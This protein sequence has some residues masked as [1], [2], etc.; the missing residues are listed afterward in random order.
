MLV[1]LS[2][3]HLSDLQSDDE[4]VERLL[5]ET[6]TSLPAKAKSIGSKKIDILWLGDIIDLLVSPQWAQRSLRPWDSPSPELGSLIENIVVAT[7]ARYARFFSTM[8]LLSEK[9]ADEVP[10]FFHY[11]IGNHDWL[12]NSSVARSAR[13][14]V[15]KAFC[16]APR[17]EGSPLAEGKSFKAYGVYAT[18]GHEFDPSN[19]ADDNLWPLGDAVVVELLQGFFNQVKAQLTEQS[20]RTLIRSLEDLFYVRPDMGVP[21]Y[22]HARLQDEGVSKRQQSIIRGAW[23]TAVN[24]FMNIP[25]FNDRMDAYEKRVGLKRLRQLLRVSRPLRRVTD[26][27]SLLSWQRERILRI[28]D[29]GQYEHRALDNLLTNFQSLKYFVMGHTH[30]AA[31]SPLFPDKDKVSKAYVNTGTWR[32]IHRPLFFERQAWKEFAAETV[33]SY[34]VFYTAEEQRSTMVSC[35]LHRRSCV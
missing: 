30:K 4:L 8:L 12:L 7:C 16:L 10:T 20:D 23:E 33:L 28:N 34:A 1:C 27:L 19:A 29:P 31:L 13:V 24:S 11:I 32:K 15:D 35:E 17:R 3:L 5:V 18:H 26:V 14:R 22:I 9:K 2:D 21:L 6:L 25:Y